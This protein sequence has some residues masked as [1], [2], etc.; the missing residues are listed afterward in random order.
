M[1]HFILISKEWNEKVIPK[2]K[3]FKVIDPSS[4]FTGFNGNSKPQLLELIRLSNRF[5]WYSYSVKTS[6]RLVVPPD[7]YDAVSSYYVIETMPLSRESLEYTTKFKNL[8]KVKILLRYGD[9]RSPSDKQMEY[10]GSTFSKSFNDLKTS[11]VNLKCK[12][13]YSSSYNEKLSD[14]EITTIFYS[15]VFSSIYLDGLTLNVNK[16]M[17]QI[18]QNSLVKIVLWTVSMS[19]WDF[20]MILQCSQQHLKFLEL[21]Y[22]TV[23]DC[24]GDYDLKQ[25]STAS[26]SMNLDRLFIRTNYRKPSGIIYFLNQIKCKN[27]KFSFRHVTTE[28]DTSSFTIENSHIE[29]FDFQNQK[30]TENVRMS[31]DLW[32]SKTTLKKIKLIDTNLTIEYCKELFNLNSLEY[33]GDQLDILLNLN[34]PKLTDII[35]QQQPRVEDIHSIIGNRYLQSI[36]LTEVN[37][38]DFLKLLNTEHP[39]IR[40][41][42]FDKVDWDN[43]TVEVPLMKESIKENKNNTK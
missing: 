38:N 42:R 15:N 29:E 17:P 36:H 28:S 9:T 41:M 3:V 11:S 32:K 20:D 21:N 1:K 8:E 16:R 13:S 12:L 6:D 14:G 5:G 34:L 18:P 40:L 22:F 39:S 10:R 19:Q 4:Y 35:V 33:R 24:D 2:L 23:L 7:L 25:L 30:I 43:I 26:H 31:L 27:L 37:F